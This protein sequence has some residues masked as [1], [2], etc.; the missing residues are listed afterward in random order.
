[1][2]G[3]QK[4]VIFLKNT[5]SHLFDEAYFVMSREGEDAAVEQ[6]DM[7]FEA[8]RIIR[9]SLGDK[10]KRIRGEGVRE[11]KTFLIPFFL[12]AVVSATLTL[13]VYSAIILFI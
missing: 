8:N 13:I 6:S 12:G 2:R 10:E 7:V 11:K 1:M 3:Y 5:G 9:E 4:K